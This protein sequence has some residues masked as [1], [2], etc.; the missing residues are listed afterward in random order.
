MHLKKEYKQDEMFQDKFSKWVE[1]KVNIAD[2][3]SMKFQ[4]CHY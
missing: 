3:Q 2:N 1:I 4:C